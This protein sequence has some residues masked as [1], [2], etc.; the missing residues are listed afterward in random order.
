MEEIDLSKFAPRSD[1]AD[2]IVTGANEG[3]DYSLINKKYK[4]VNISY[5]T[6]HSDN[7]SFNKKKGDY[8]SIEF[9]M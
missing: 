4:D 2:E 5:I 3:K 1:L 8:V 7:N 9:Q 6:I